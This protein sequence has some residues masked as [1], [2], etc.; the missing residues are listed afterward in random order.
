MAIY[1]TRGAPPTTLTDREV[2][3]VLGETGRTSRTL[4]DHV[5]LSLALGSGAREHELAALD[6]AD[7]VLPGGEIR[8]RVKLRTFKG[9]RGASR[10][11]A[12]RQWLVLA[13]E[14]RRKLKLYVR[15]LPRGPLFPSQKGG[16]L[17]TRTIRELWQKVQ[18]RAGLERHHPFH[19]LRHTYLSN[20]YDRTRNPVLVQR[21]GRHASMETT[22]I[23]VAVSDEQQERAHQ[24][25]P[26]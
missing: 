10:A 21:A 26:C 2:R 19:A 14:C 13:P 22:L 3:L 16:R 6:R 9:C 11:T 1:A 5:L 7:V 15:G 8:R 23:Y 25:I 4:R 24:S 18:L 20:L 17:A 12:N